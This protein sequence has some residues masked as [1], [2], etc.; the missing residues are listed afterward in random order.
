MMSRAVCS[1]PAALT[2][3]VPAVGEG[4]VVL[5]VTVA[6]GALLPGAADGGPVRAER[7]G[8]TLREVQGTEVRRL[9]RERPHAVVERHRV[10]ARRSAG[11]VVM[12]R[13]CAGLRVGTDDRQAVGRLGDGYLGALQQVLPVQI[14]L[15]PAVPS[16]AFLRGAGRCQ[17]IG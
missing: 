8:E 4:E 13:V 6:V 2:S 9:P 16:R 7:A 3:A 1:G 10:Q 15:E 17:L 11:V 14:T 12:L 5:P